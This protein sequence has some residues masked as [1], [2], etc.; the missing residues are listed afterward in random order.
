MKKV[1]IKY[2]FRGICIK[3]NQWLFGDLVHDT[4]GNCYVYPLD[5][6][7]LYIGNKVIKETVGQF[8]G[9][10]DCCGHKIYEGDI[11]L[12]EDATIDDINLKKNIGIVV[13]LKNGSFVEN[14]IPSIKHLKVVSN[15]YEYKKKAIN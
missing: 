9:L 7:G 12:N 3:T 14:I 11:L 6:G 4:E 5:C 8:T 15:I 10:Y 2:S 1:K 13:Q